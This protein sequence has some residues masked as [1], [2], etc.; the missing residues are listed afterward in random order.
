LTDAYAANG[1]KGFWQQIQNANEKTGRNFGEFDIPQVYARLGE[2]DL[3][4]E[5]LGR[6]YESRTNFTTYMNVDPAYDSMRSNPR[7]ENLARRIGLA[8]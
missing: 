2:K 6:N 8:N 3:A 1:P 7:F 5:W 4:L